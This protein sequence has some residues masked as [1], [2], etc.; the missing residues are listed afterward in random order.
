MVSQFLGSSDDGGVHDRISG[1]LGWGGS[2][3]FESVL[4]SFCTSKAIGLKWTMEWGGAEFHLAHRTPLID[5]T[6]YWNAKPHSRR[7]LR[8]EL[9]RVHEEDTRWVLLEFWRRLDS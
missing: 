3:V 8:Q 4:P 1:G 5:R 6:I 9:N 2:N 7:L